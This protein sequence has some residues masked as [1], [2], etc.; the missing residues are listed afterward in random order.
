MAE[1]TDGKIRWDTKIRGEAKR[2]YRWWS[3]ER[4]KN[5]PYR[6]F[7]DPVN[8]ENGALIEAR[9]LRIGGAIEV[10][11]ARTMRV[12]RT[13]TAKIAD[14]GPHKGKAVIHID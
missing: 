7:G 4:K 10:Y 5:L 13:Y 12:I 11:D 2:P 8:A 1:K 6:C 14:S 9:W 3:A